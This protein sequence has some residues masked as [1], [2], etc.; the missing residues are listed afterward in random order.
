LRLLDAVREFGSGVASWPRL[1]AILLVRGPTDD[2]ADDVLLE[3]KEVG[4]SGIAGL[5]P[6]GVYHDSVGQRVVHSARGAW[7]RADAEP[8]WGWTDLLGFPCQIRRESEGQKNV[9]VARMAGGEGTPEAIAALATTL[10]TLVARVHA[11][12]P[13]GIDNAR[14]IYK[15]IAS[16]PE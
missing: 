11:S 6:P 2:P 1:R 4:D 10:G 15:R 7:A 8:L 16:S 12:G 14:A 13:A 9:R 3:L 5:Y